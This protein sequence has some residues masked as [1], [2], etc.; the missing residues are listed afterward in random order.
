MAKKKAAA[1]DRYAS[2]VEMARRLGVNRG[3]IH[4]WTSREGFPGGAAGPW[5]LT[6]IIRW[7]IN[8][9]PAKVEDED[10][11][12]RGPASP[13]LEKY[14]LAKAGREELK[15]ESERKNLISR[16]DLREALGKWAALLKQASEIL[17]QRFGVDAQ[18]VLND[19]LDGCQEIIETINAKN[20]G[21]K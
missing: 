14:R 20:E 18:Q 10:P 17:G 16:Q 3:T 12:M 11:A 19:K 5:A 6:D 8:R 15:L 2:K 7:L 1:T 13:A 4:D 21:D 9:S